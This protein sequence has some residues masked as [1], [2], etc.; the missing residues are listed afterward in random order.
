M[1]KNFAV[2]GKH[3]DFYRKNRWIELEGLLSANQVA[4]IGKEIENITQER[5]KAHK[6]TNATWPAETQFLNGHDLWRAGTSIKKVVLN[7][8]FAEAASSL[9]EVRP[10]RIGYDQAYC[11]PADGKLGIGVYSTLLSSTPTL[12]E[13]SS[14]QG[15]VCGLMLCI[16]AAAPELNSIDSSTIFPVKEGNGVMF[17]PDLPIN[18]L[19]LTHRAGYVYLLIVYVQGKAV[20]IHHDSDP[21][22]NE[23]RKLGYTFGDKLS[24]TLNPTVYQ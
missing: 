19:E 5:Q 4:A 9:V 2:D 16:K 11:V 10:L 8:G 17:A 3:R 12:Q 23:F 6:T 13:L 14:I 24:E 7:R 1:T 21:H 20:Y 18:F 22:L 15:V